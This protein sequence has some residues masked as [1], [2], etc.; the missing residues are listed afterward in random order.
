VIRTATQ[1]CLI[2]ENQ[3][4]ILM[5]MVESRKLTEQSYEEE[6]AE[7]LAH[8]IPHYHELMKQLVDLV[9]PGS[10]GDN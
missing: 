3:A 8:D 5:N 7:Q 4:I 2:T 10:N 1:A 9:K 6:I